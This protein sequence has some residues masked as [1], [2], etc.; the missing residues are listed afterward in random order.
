MDSRRALALYL[1]KKELLP[2]TAAQ[3]AEISIIGTCHFQSWRSD[4]VPIE[5]GSTA[6]RTNSA[7]GSLRPQSVHRVHARGSPCWN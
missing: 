7:L 5:S 2:A 6:K 1:M 4:S 3:R